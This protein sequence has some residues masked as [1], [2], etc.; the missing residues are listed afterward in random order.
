MKRKVCVFTGTRAEYGLLRPLLVKLSNDSRIELQLVVSGMHLSEKFGFTYK[1][2]ESDGFLIDKKVEILDDEDSAKSISRA[3]GIGIA[4]FTKAFNELKPEIVV[5]LGDRFEALAAATACQIS[6]TPVAHI[7]GGEATEGLMD[8]A[9]RHA[10]TKMSHLHF[11]STKEY[12]KRVIQL[13]ENPERVFLVG[14]L[15]VENI[16]SAKFSSREDLER[17][18]KLRF[19]RTNILITFHPVTLESDTAKDQIEE[20]LVV[21][22]DLQETTCIFTYPNSDP[23]GLQVIH[24]IDKFVS[25]HKNAYAFASLGQRNY[26]SCVNIVDVVIGNSSSGLIEVPS[27]GKPTINIGDRQL[28]RVKGLSVIDSLPRSSDIKGALEVALS[29]D[30]RRKRLNQ[31]NPYELPETSQK[32]AEI[33]RETPLTTILKKHFWDLEFSCE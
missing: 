3:I 31:S 17:D 15:G 5:I 30:F 16:R 27:L 25:E 32:I 2:I 10:I 23:G 4:E 11:V 1:E 18:L 9:F 20:L 7:Y 13:G 6:R 8:E 28:G 22:K 26:F 12:Q 24:A 21:L 33:L 29:G 14:S 19:S